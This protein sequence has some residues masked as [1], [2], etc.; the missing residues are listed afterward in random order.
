MITIAIFYSLPVIQL[1]LQY[2]L[3]IDAIGNEDIC[4]FN[5]LCT[6][7][8]FRLTAFNNIFSNIGYSALGV[9]FLIIVYRRYEKVGLFIKI[10]YFY[11]D[12]NRSYTQF[13]TREPQMARVKL[14][15]I[16]LFFNSFFMSLGKWYTTTFWSFLRNGYWFN[17]GRNN[18]CMVKNLFNIFFL[19]KDSF[20]IVIMFVHRDKIFNLIQALCLLSLY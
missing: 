2:Q 8:L 17:H 5:F 11:F 1:V 12:R 9:L 16:K 18:E 19:L 10:V 4:Y 14:N 7:E 20:F 3:N 6:R 13:L 15:K